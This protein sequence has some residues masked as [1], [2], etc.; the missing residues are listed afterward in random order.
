[1]V[2]RAQL[3]TH[4]ARNGETVRRLKFTKRGDW[5]RAADGRGVIGIQYSRK[6]KRYYVAMLPLF[7]SPQ[8]LGDF[9]TR[10]AAEGFANATYYGT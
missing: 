5:W 2:Q 6:S 3:H 10:R 1:M 9:T 4:R 7:G 8:I